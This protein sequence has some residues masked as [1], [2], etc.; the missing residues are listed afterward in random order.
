MTFLD[1]NVPANKNR[2]QNSGNCMSCCGELEIKVI[3]SA[4]ADSAPLFGPFFG[5]CKELLLLQTEL[6]SLH[7]FHS[8]LF[9]ELYI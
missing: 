1:R 4:A 7:I 8:N 3:C 2:K 6:E 9:F 5:I